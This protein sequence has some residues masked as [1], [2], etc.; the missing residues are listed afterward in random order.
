MNKD[1]SVIHSKFLKHLKRNGYSYSNTRFAHGDCYYYAYAMSSILDHFK[2]NHKILSYYR[3]DLKSGHCFIKIKNQYIDS[4]NVY[5]PVDNW[6]KLQYYMNRVRK[7]PIL[8]KNRITALKHWRAKE[9][10]EFFDTQVKQFI[11][12]LK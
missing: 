6:K 10:K 12:G 3:K 5:S 11:K 1:I 2:V 9:D 7:K 4:E 8:H